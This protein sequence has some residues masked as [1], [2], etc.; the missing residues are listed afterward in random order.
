MLLTYI[1]LLNGMDNGERVLPLK[2]TEAENYKYFVFNKIKVGKKLTWKNARSLRSEWTYLDVMKTLGEDDK[3]SLLQS[4]RSNSQ[5]IR[6]MEFYIYIYKC[7]GCTV[8]RMVETRF[9]ETN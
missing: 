8:H 3:I 9:H 2:K 1:I 5:Q 4:K 7:V 6:G